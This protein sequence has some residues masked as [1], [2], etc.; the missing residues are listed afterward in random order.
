MIRPFVFSILLLSVLSAFGQ[1]TVSG[2]YTYYVPENVTREVAKRTALERARVQALAD[3][4][5]TIVTQQNETVIRNADGH[6]QIDF[7]SIGESE[8][9]GIWIQTVEE[10]Y[11]EH[12]QEG[13]FVVTCYVKGLARAVSNAIPEFE[14]H[15]MRNRIDTEAFDCTFQSEDS[16]FMT[17]SAACDGYL[18]V[19]FVDDERNQ[20]QCILPHAEQGEGYYRI[21]RGKQ[22]YFFNFNNQDGMKAYNMPLVLFSEKEVEHAHFYVL[23][24]PKDKVFTVSSKLRL[25][26]NVFFD[27]NGNQRALPLE[28]PKKQFKEWLNKCLNRDKHMQRAIKPITIIKKNE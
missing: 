6:S 11:D 15:L 13:I 2:S 28:M 26:G 24:S 14:W 27:P 7:L 4:F 10:T 1:K 17:F 9:G 16:L 22:Y 25:S 5:G 23:F 3:E 20:V 19:F 21:K 18:A 8:V 12:F